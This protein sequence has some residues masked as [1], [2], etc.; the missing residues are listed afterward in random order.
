MA[1]LPYSVS[2]IV[3]NLY[4]IMTWMSGTRSPSS[5]APCCSTSVTK[6]GGACSSRASEMK[7]FKALSFI[8]IRSF[9]NSNVQTASGRAVGS[10][11]VSHFAKFASEMW[12]NGAYFD[13]TN[14]RALR[15]QYR[16]RRCNENR[17]SM[18][19]VRMQPRADRRPHQRAI[20][21]RSRLP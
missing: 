13:A 6:P 21:R 17:C 7:A 19:P 8:A 5:S 3:R 18:R 12:R 14:R 20:T 1:G 4:G 15:S 9:S 10:V 2:M 11:T 16:S